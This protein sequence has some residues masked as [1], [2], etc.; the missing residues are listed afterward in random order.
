MI[1]RV[2]S[3]AC[4]HVMATA[5]DVVGSVARP[6]GT[7]AISAR[8]I[9]DSSEWRASAAC[10]FSGIVADHG[11]GCVTG[12][13]AAIAAWF[14]RLMQ[15]RVASAAG[16]FA[17]IVAFECVRAS[18][19]VFA[20]DAAIGAWRADFC[21]SAAGVWLLLVDGFFTDKFSGI[22]A[23]PSAILTWITRRIFKCVASAAGILARIVTF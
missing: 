23:R 12:I 13:F 1:K 19:F 17:W 14:I 18:T 5:N 21:H 20:A 8:C 22:I 11:I 16:I 2:A 9:R 3:P 10:V 6:C 15:K 4:V 7:F